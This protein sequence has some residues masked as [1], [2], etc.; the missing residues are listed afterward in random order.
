MSEKQKT[1]DHNK[2]E[3][4]KIS[5][6]SIDTEE[7]RWAV[8]IEYEGDKQVSKGFYKQELLQD[9]IAGEK[10]KVTKELQ[11]K[12]MSTVK[13]VASKFMPVDTVR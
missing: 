7:D 3:E 13:K 11:D 5:K 9:L 8:I 6:K 10:E 1:L 2:Y 4:C 12:T